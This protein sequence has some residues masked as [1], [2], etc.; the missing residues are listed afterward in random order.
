MLFNISWTWIRMVLINMLALSILMAT[1]LGVGWC[2]GV[3]SG[4]A[5]VKRDV[6]SALRGGARPAQPVKIAHVGTFVSMGKVL[7]WEAK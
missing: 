4:R 1:C 2:L 7:F 3:Q 6:V 5:E